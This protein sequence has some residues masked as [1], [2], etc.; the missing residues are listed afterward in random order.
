MIDEELPLQRSCGATAAY[1]R[2]LEIDPGFQQ[3]QMELEL[4][5]AQAKMLGISA[6]KPETVKI[7][8][9]VHILYN[10]DQE[11]I[12]DSQVESQIEV[13]NYDF[14]AKNS[15]IGEVPDVWKPLVG[16]ANIEF[17]LTE[18]F[19]AIQRIKTAKTRFGFNDS[20]KFAAQGGADSIEPERILNVW[21]CNLA[22]LLGYAQF[23]G[24]IPQTDGVVINYQAFGTNG[25]AQAPFDLGR[26]TTHEIGHW[27]NLRHI[28]GD[29]LDCSGT[30]HVDDTPKALEPNY[31][32]KTF[33]NVTC[34][35][36]PNGDMFVNYMDYS[37]DEAMFMFTRGQVERMAATFL[38]P[39]IGFVE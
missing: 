15:D 19:P 28:W 34:N 37:D 23:P 3:R 25:T 9:I 2:M 22:G 6:A 38:G 24:G 14:R 26:T 21:V 4:F 7:P 8:T 12:S 13:L 33:P 27:L 31:G 20:V 11:N 35:N 18:E 39:R 32:S 16:D 30:D 5:T 36:G 1:Y 29:T 10:K 17:Y